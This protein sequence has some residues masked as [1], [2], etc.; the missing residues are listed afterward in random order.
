MYAEKNGKKIWTVSELMADL[1]KSLVMPD[2]DFVKMAPVYTGAVN[3]G[4]VQAQS[5]DGGV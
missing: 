4:T 5:V 3:T 2:E 1:K